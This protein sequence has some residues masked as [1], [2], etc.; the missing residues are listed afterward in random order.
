MIVIVI[1]ILCFTTKVHSSSTSSILKLLN[2]QTQHTEH[3][4]HCY[5][6]AR[7]E[8]ERAEGGLQYPWCYR[9]AVTIHVANC[10]G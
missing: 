1:L 5:V 9:K 4:G 10:G 7:I 8:R 6:A 3:E 2:H